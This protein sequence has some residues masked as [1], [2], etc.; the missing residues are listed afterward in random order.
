[1]LDGPT[2][3]ELA[4]RGV[5]ADAVTFAGFVLGMA[6][7]ISIVFGQFA[8]AVGL[9]LLGRLS[10]GLDGAVARATRKTDF[11]GYLD[12]VLDFIFYGSVPLAFAILDPDRNALAAATLLAAYFANGSAFLALAI[13]AERRGIETTAQ[14][15]KSLYYAAGLAEGAETIVVMIL[16]CVV[17]DY[18]TAIAY[19]YAAV[20]TVSAGA[21]ILLAR[22]MLG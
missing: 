9:I 5:S 1:M 11:G 3:T 22:R 17:P 19:V 13:M 4:R 16:F 21:R 6:G 7:A 14:G 8:L 15:Q 12:I 2:G 10:D 20:C 18:F